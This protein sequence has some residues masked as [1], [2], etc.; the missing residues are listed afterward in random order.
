MQHEQA[1]PHH[2]EDGGR[3]IMFLPDGGRIQDGGK[4]LDGGCYI[5]GGKVID[6][7]GI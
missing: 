3:F 6:P 7:E 4:I 2:G 1:P 5:D